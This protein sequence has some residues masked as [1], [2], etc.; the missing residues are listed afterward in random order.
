MNYTEFSVG[1]RVYKLRLTTKAIVDFERKMGVNPLGIFGAKGDI[2]PTVETLVTL[3]WASLQQYE[4]GITIN[5][6]YDI[7]DAWLQ[8]NTITDFMYIIMDM[9][10]V[11]G[12]VKEVPEADKNPN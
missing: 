8:E 4:H 6:T 2:F 11:C 9:Y 3:L 1:D 5:N 10:K 7:F 12:L